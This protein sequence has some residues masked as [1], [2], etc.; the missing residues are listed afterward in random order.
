MSGRK[1]RQA[2][3][4]I[5]MK[6]RELQLIR[7]DHTSLIPVQQKKD[8]RRKTRKRGLRI[9]TRAVY[10]H[11]K[12]AL[13]IQYHGEMKTGDSRGQFLTEPIKTIDT[14]NRYG[15]VTAFV[16]KFYKSGADWKQRC[17]D[18]GSETG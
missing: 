5:V 7:A 3:E 14:S 1:E 15:L 12:D 13:L 4:E 8:K 9:F 2:V 18:Y 6:P 17:T 10:K 16:T 11:A